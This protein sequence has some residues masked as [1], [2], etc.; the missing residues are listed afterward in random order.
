MTRA[1]ARAQEVGNRRAESLCYHALGAVQYL[2]GE[3][4]GSREAF[5]QSVSLAWDV[6]ATFGVVLGEQRLALLETGLGRLDEARERLLRVLDIARNSDNMM[7][8]VHSF[9]RV[10]STLCLN[11]LEAGDLAGAT[12]YL[13]QGLASQ[14]ET[15]ECIPCD[16]LLYPAAVPVY[17]GLGDMDRAKWACARAEDTAATFGSLA[18]SAVTSHLRGILASA[19]GDSES[20][21]LNL[22]RALEQ[23][24]ELEQP[25]DVASTLEALGDLAGSPAKEQSGD[26]DSR[27]CFERALETYRMLGARPGEERV[28]A[29]LAEVIRHPH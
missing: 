7:V 27:D 28:T 17:I 22:R 5:N 3:W 29:K 11:R 21:A 19:S 10:L 25:Y 6:G 14:Q 24:Q 2:R 9:T 23:F 1:L 26:V 20:A 4:S 12:D 13:A 15:G 8:Q 18:W 16:A